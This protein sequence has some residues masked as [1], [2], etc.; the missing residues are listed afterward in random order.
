MDFDARRKLPYSHCSFGIVFH[1]ILLHTRIHM[2]S[3]AHK[4]TKRAYDWILTFG[5]KI[6]FAVVVFFI[7]QWLIRMLNRWF[8][9]IISNQQVDIT[10]RP[11]LQNL[12]AIV[13]QALLIVALMQVLGIQMTIFA[14]LIGA[15]GVA[16]GLAL[17]GTFQ[18]FASGVLII[19]L[20]PFR[21]GDTVN[22]QG[23]E[24]TVTAI[25]LFYTIIL[26]FNNTTVIVPNSKLSNEIIF[27]LSK[28][29]K[30]RIDIEIKFN[31]GVDFERIKTIV[32]ATVDS[33]DRETKDPP[34]RI[35]LQKFESDGYTMVI[36]VWTKARGFQDTRLS[37]QELLLKNIKAQGIKL[38]GMT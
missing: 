22:T 6:I 23:Q 3:L 19:L 15:F 9:K 16:A 7:G 18:N 1:V 14:A 30:R 4:F 38:P 17:S 12:F 33:F 28:E 27:N 2:D 31:Y 11:F 20:K 10:L 21:V 25:R 5:P 35:G 24:G 37:F 26:T 13:L 36:N 32:L 29:G 8:K 34:P